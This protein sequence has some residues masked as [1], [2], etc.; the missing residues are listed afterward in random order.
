MAEGQSIP[1]VEAESWK[2]IPNAPGY[3]ISSHGRVRSWQVRG[4][5]WKPGR[6]DKPHVLKTKPG[7]GGYLV[8][9]LSIDGRIQT[10]PVHRL[11]AFAFLG[12]PKSDKLEV[13]HLDGD[14]TNNRADNLAWGTRKENAD[15]RTRH[16][17]T[18][19]GE[20]Q[21]GAKLNARLV[22]EIYSL[23]NS[24]R[25]KSQIG[26]QFNISRTLVSLIWTGRKWKHVTQHRLAELTGGESTEGSKP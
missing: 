7:R 21:P 15:D 8:V 19:R 24:G 1:I 17:R 2:P 6:T 25:S 9:Y 12:E 3:E 4:F 23:R 26:R 5:A 13:R 20:R 10:L 16:G 11:A 14:P 18:A 22:L